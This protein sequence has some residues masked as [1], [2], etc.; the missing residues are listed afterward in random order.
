MLTDNLDE[1]KIV[2]AGA[3]STNELP[4]SIGYTYTNGTPDTYSGVQT[5]FTKTLNTNPEEYYKVRIDKTEYKTRVGYTNS[6][7]EV[8]LLSGSLGNNAK[9]IKHISVVNKDTAS[10]TVIVALQKSSVLFPV[11]EV[12]LDVGD[13]LEYTE[14]SG[15]RVLTSAG[16]IKSGGSSGASMV[17]PSAGLAV[18]TGTAWSASIANNSANWNTA[19]GWG[20]HASAGYLTSTGITP[21]ALTKTDDTNVTITL[22]G[23]PA[24]ALLQATS[25]TVG[26]TGTL[27]D[28]RVASA[29]TWNAKEPPITA[30]T[31]AQYWRGDKSWQTLNSAAV[32]LGSVEN[33]ALSTWAGT[34]NIT[35]LG[36]IATGTWSGATIG[37]TKGGTGEVTANAGFN[38]LAPSQTGN[39]GKY[40]TTNGTTTSWATV[41][42]GGGSLSALTAAT[43]ANTIDNTSFAQHW[44]FNSL[45]AGNALQLSSSATTDAA[46]TQTLFQ[47][48]ATG[49]NAYTSKAFGVD[50]TKTGA[51]VNIGLR[52]KVSGAASNIALST[53]PNT[54]SVFGATNDNTGF[55]AYTPVQIYQ[56]DYQNYSLYSE[57][58]IQVRESSVIG[59]AF[60]N[61]PGSAIGADSSGLHLYTNGYDIVSA[62][63]IGLTGA[64]SI[65]KSG[66][67]AV[68][69]SI[70]DVVSTTK[71]AL[72]PRMTTTQRDAIS[73]PATGLIVYNTTTNKLNIFT[74]AWEE[75][76]SI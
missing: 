63:R 68:A 39:S 34:A 35:T 23:T 2:L 72:L 60:T 64:V 25:L 49:N 18:S 61:G 32:G 76:T 54:I 22:G 38:A 50:M 53:G 55:N 56:K 21:A 36:T 47:L 71:G 12:T 41:A 16:E 70:L 15:W 58:R 1:I 73:S 31:I 33:T 11:L 4:Y 19:Y 9:I 10:A 17:Y 65:G 57:G 13:N 40:L 28:A 3:V 27:A 20:N 52:L 66:T 67:I 26:W 51:G 29:T 5:E 24:T 46:G 43:A 74:T 8:T 37:I 44:Q 69:S 7:T 14:A 62:L 59:L 6:T 42:G 45:T 48:N 75:V 30:G